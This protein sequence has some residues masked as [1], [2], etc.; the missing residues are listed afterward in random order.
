MTYT[1]KKAEELTDYQIQK[2][3]ELW[4]HE[5]WNSLEPN[6]FKNLFKDSEFHMLSD[7]KEEIASVLRLN[8][9]F[10]LKIAD[11][12]YSFTE[13]GGLVS[14]QKRLGYGSKLVQL[15]AENVAQRNL[16]TI[17][18]CFSD[19]RPFYEKCSVE[20]LADIAKNIKEKEGGEWVISEDDDILVIHLSE[21]KKNLLSQLTP[22]NY[23]YLIQ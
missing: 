16:E 15:V 11:I 4:E 13:M 1:I 5:E 3:I 21:E 6:D 23:A 12:L 7:A 2:I 19:L 20:I 10:V 18:F 14:S 8:F 9:D 22:E 17:G